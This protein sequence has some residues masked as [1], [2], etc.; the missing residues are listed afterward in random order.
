MGSDRGT[1][2]MHKT[3][4]G[5]ATNAAGGIA[6][7][8]RPVQAFVLVHGAWH[9][10]WC[11]SRV[12]DR[13]RAK[14]HVVFTPTTGLGERKHLLSKDITLD[15]FTADIVNLIEC[16]ELNDMVLVGHSFGRNAISGVADIIL[17]ESVISSISTR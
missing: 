17:C 16:E 10:G 8:Q 15:T 6:T 12:A 14:G 2:D 13:L 1:S 5:S 7:A 11:W 9:G 3:V 4:T